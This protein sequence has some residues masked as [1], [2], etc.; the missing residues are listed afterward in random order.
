[1]SN[2][3]I[4]Q[5]CNELQIKNFKGVFMR[6]E[7]NK[8]RKSTNNECLILNIDHSKNNGTHWTCLFINNGISYYFDS[9]GLTPPLEVLDYCKGERYFNS[10]KIQQDQEVICGHYCIYVLYRLSRGY[11]FYDILD[12]L[13]RFKK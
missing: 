11:N 13:V 9:Y 7:L 3:E 4:I 5:K 10:F 2:F 12:E 1:L 6:D 8:N